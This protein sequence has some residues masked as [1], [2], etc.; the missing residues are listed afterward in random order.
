VF[1]LFIGLPLLFIIVFYNKRK[2]ES[3]NTFASRLK[4]M[5]KSNI[6]SIRIVGFYLVYKTI[7]TLLIIMCFVLPLWI[8]FSL[9]AYW[10]TQFELEKLLKFLTERFH[11]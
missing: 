2:I 5:L 1:E 8:C 4:I 11:E 9:E 10:V 3:W 6:L 7:L